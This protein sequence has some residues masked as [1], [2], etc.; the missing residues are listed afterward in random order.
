[1]EEGN[2][3]TWYCYYAVMQLNWK[4]RD[5]A[6]LPDKERALMYAFIDEKIKNEKKQAGKI[7]SSSRRGRR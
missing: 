2:G 3:D 5:F 4:P 6:F 7:K 1:M